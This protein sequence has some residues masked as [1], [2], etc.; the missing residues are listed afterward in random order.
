MNI[1]YTPTRIAQQFHDSK[2]IMRVLVGPIACGKTSAAIMDLTLNKPATAAPIVFIG[3]T[4]PSLNHGL[5]HTCKNWL[6]GASF[7]MP[8]DSLN[9]YDG[10]LP[11]CGNR[12]VAFAFNQWE[13]IE[14]VLA[15][16]PDFS[17]A[18]VTNGESCPRFV[19]D[20]L[21]AR[22]GR[23]GPSERSIIV[24][25]TGFAGAQRWGTQLGTQFQ[26]TFW[27]P[28]AFLYEGAGKWIVNPHAENTENLPP[29]YYSR[30]LACNI[31]SNHPELL[32]NIVRETRILMA[33]EPSADI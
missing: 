32:A 28:S 8:H 33:G 5:L 16:L 10:T 6:P 3:K 1:N 21:K 4:I 9:V 18:I 26:S 15:E 12:V 25:V 23:E 17:K 20:V 24:D 7:N 27:Y 31:L 2:A 29:E 11:I 13:C 14:D 22:C 19:L 30:L